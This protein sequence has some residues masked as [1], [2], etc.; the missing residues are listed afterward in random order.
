MPVTLELFNDEI[1]FFESTAQAVLKE[2]FHDGWFITEGSFAKL[3]ISAAS[4]EQKK[5]LLRRLGGYNPK[6]FGDELW[7]N[8]N[9]ILDF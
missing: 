4:K 7:I 8:L 6:I 3:D 5:I 9:E 1:K 2:K